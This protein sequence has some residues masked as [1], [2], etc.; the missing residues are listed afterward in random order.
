[1]I[2]SCLIGQTRLTW[3]VMPSIM[4][5]SFF[6]CST[7]PDWCWYNARSMGPKCHHFSRNYIHSTYVTI[8]PLPFFHEFLLMVDPSW[9]RAVII[10]NLMW[11]FLNP[12]KVSQMAKR[13]TYCAEILFFL[14][15]NIA[16][17]YAGN[18]HSRGKLN[19][20]LNCYFGE[21]TFLRR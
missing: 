13:V 10:Y 17:C 8:R 14:I 6:Y 5:H 11:T 20:T 21:V 4:G 19:R 2:W 12:I 3:P 1:M 7:L 18:R 16:T 15:S 9:T